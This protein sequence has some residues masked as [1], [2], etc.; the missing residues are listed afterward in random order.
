M[1]T[2]KYCLLFSFKNVKS[3]SDLS[4]LPLW[5]L[6]GVLIFIRLLSKHGFWLGPVGGDGSAGSKREIRH[7]HL[8]PKERIYHIRLFFLAFL[9]GSKVPPI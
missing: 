9:A 5:F 4:L 7:S 3:A 8:V 6:L 1:V 2:R